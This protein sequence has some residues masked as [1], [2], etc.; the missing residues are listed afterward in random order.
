MKDYSKECLESLPV[1]ADLGLLEQGYC[2]TCLN[3]LCARSMG[4]DLLWLAR[5]HRQEEALRHP[6]SAVDP[7]L[8]EY[9]PIHM[10]GFE[11]LSA[12]DKKIWP[13]VDVDSQVLVKKAPPEKKV[14]SADQLET[15]RNSLR[16]EASSQE[17][18]LV[19]EEVAGG[20]VVRENIKSVEERAEPSQ[21]KAV[22]SQ[23]GVWNTPF[24]SE[25]VVLPGGPPSTQHT[26]PL[27]ESSTPQIVQEDPWEIPALKGGQKKKKVFRISDGK[28]VKKGG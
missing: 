1:E 5:M 6:G 27:S 23:T 22:D 2:V 20:E 3:A 24:P 15:S 25:G 14:A 11:S 10:Q 8:P 7:T 19:E 21:K 16:K 13:S 17:E 28:Q 4:K 26:T 18:P 9:A 12:Q